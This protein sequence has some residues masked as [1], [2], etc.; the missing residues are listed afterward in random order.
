MSLIKI[1]IKNCKY[2]YVYLSINRRAY[3]TFSQ[4]Y[5]S[6]NEL[7]QGLISHGEPLR[8][9]VRFHYRDFSI[10]GKRSRFYP[11]YF[12]IITRFYDNY[13]RTRLEDHSVFFILCT[14]REKE[15]KGKYPLRINNRRVIS[16]YFKCQNNQRRNYKL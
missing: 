2:I 8:Y 16:K 3:F 12:D 9:F 5:F 4:F 13:W 14:L 7:P 11:S 15:K 6:S 10:R 1:G